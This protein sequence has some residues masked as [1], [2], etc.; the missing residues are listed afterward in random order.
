MTKPALKRKILKLLN[1]AIQGGLSET[2]RTCGN[3]KCPCHTDKARR[4]GPNLYLTFKTLDGRSSGLYIPRDHEKQVRK[5]VLDW[6]KLWD[7]L[8]TY[9]ALNREDLRETMRRSPSRRRPEDTK[10]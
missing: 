7:A 8:V 3:K 1:T 5:A 4:H 10:E 6:G 2:T 9:A